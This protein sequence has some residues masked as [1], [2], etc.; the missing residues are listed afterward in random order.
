MGERAELNPGTTGFGLS[1]RSSILPSRIGSTGPAASPFVRPRAGRGRRNV[2]WATTSTSWCIVSAND[3]RGCPGTERIRPSGNFAGQRT[4]RRAITMRPS[5]W[6]LSARRRPTRTCDSTEEALEVGFPPLLRAI[7]LRVA[8]GGF[9]PGMGLLGTPGRGGWRNVSTRRGDA[10]EFFRYPEGTIPLCR[11]G[12]WILSRL[13]CRSGHV[14]RYEQRDV[15][16]ARSASTRG[17]APGRTPTR[18]AR[19]CASRRPRRVKAC[20]HGHSPRTA[21]SPA[22]PGRGRGR[23]ARRGQGSV[24]HRNRRGS[25]IPRLSRSSTQQAA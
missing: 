8:N 20:S 17:S 11:W 2:P 15:V 22:P 7:Y 10:W 3:A 21:T 23:W 24:A 6:G 18:T 12:C 25:R 14:L 4:R 16:E 1:R 19:L 13:D 5:G 9:G